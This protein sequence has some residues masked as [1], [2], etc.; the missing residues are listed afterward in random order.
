MAI[1]YRMFCDYE[2]CRESVPASD[3]MPEG[4]AYIKTKAAAFG[5]VKEMHFCEPTHLSL[6]VWGVERDETEA[7]PVEDEANV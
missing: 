6:H 1:E 7:E 4:W 5:T 3:V 2:H